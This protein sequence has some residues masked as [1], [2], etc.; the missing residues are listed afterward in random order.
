MTGPSQHHDV[1]VIG[2]GPQGLLYATWLKQKRPGTRV[3]VLERDRRPGYKIGESTLVG[4][5]RA[6]LS[7]GLSAPLLNLLFFRKDGIGYFYAR[8]AEDE[9][10]RLPSLFVTQPTTLRY[11]ELHHVERRLLDHLLESNARRHGVEI[12]RGARV[13]PERCR[14]GLAGS[15]VAYQQDGGHHRLTAHLVVDA[16]GPARLLARH[17]GLAEAGDLQTSSLW[18]YTRN[19]QPYRA[20]CWRQNLRRTLHFL[21]PEGWLWFIPIDSWQHLPD[22]VEGGLV[23]G[24][25][26][27][28]ELPDRQGLLAERGVSPQTI[29]SV[30]LTLRDDRNPIVKGRAADVFRFYAERH[31]VM[32]PI[33]D[34]ENIASG[35]YRDRGLE[36]YLRRNV[37]YSSSRFAGDGWLLIGDAAFF[38]DPFFGYGLNNGAAM[39]YYAA[40]VTAQ[41]LNGDTSSPAAFSGYDDWMRRHHEVFNRERKIFYLSF[42]HPT[43]FAT[44]L[45]LKSRFVRPFMME[46]D[47]HEFSMADV[48]I[49][50]FLN[51]RFIR[52]TEELYKLMSDEEKRVDRLVP[53]ERQSE[54]DYENMVARMR[55]RAADLVPQDMAMLP[56]HSWS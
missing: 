22:E 2:A 37:H 16:S 18:F 53:L 55:Q 44:Y 19:L 39:A 14:F 27:S 17:L 5:T 35:H 41:F 3:V 20:D 56:R 1:V 7:A 51:P 12:I 26:Q 31:P 33:L 9:L 46:R 4:F 23:E 36:R 8:R 45:R 13:M 38:V 25:L 42:N 50:D 21:F 54:S 30:G 47:Q 43:A 34:E 52:L 40:E 10:A 24:L 15:S 49:H 48:N 6:L 32:Q 29:V 11:P 28:G